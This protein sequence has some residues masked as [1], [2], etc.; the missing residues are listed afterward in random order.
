MKEMPGSNYFPAI[1]HRDKR[2]VEELFWGRWV[3]STSLLF[4][5]L[6]SHNVNLDKIFSQHICSLMLKYNTFSPHWQFL[7]FTVYI[8]DGED[9]PKGPPPLGGD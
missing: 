8:K 7:K 5:L 3:E 6:I 4:V 2:W 9:L 1:F